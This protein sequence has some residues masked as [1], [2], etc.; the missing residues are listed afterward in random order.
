MGSYLL[1]D[2]WPQL[3]SV[4]AS[5]SKTFSTRSTSEDMVRLGRWDSQEINEED[6]QKL[7]ITVRD[8]RHEDRQADQGKIHQ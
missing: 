3:K 2:E 6:W 5:I 1:D 7:E 8:A 4:P